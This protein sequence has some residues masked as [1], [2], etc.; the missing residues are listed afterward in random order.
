MKTDYTGMRFSD[1]LVKK[2]IPEKGKK[3]KN[4]CECSCG[5]K[6]IVTSSNLATGHT[7]SCGCIVK[8]HGLSHKE[9]LYN[10]WIG[11]RQRCRDSNSPDYH[12]Y[13]ERGIVVCKEWNESYLSFREWAM[14]HGYGD[15][16]SIDRKDVNGNYE[17]DNCRWANMIEQNNNLRSNRLIEYK[18]NIHTLAEWAKILDIPY[19]L[20]KQRFHRGWSFN[21]IVEVGASHVY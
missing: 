9:R 5:N 12:K 11:M 3:T 21:R 16:L 6:V 15:S 7:K 17:P 18:G 8:K 2:R 13:G 19:K 4:L 14:S 20:I 1:L 10:I